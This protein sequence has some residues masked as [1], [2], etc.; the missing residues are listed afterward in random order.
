MF[1]RYDESKPTAFDEAIRG[2]HLAILHFV[3]REFQ[4]RD[5][6]VFAGQTDGTSNGPFPLVPEAQ[7]FEELPQYL[8]DRWTASTSS[9][10]RS[11][12]RAN[13]RA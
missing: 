11:M 5:S 9:F 13:N 8:Q 2:G 12:T 6:A 1:P 4:L 3:H 10:L 7:L